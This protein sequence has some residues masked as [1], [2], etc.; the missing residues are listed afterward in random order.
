MSQ[1]QETNQLRKDPLTGKWVIIG[2]RMGKIHNHNYIYDPCQFC[3]EKISR[4]K[5]IARYPYGGINIPWKVLVI[6]NKYALFGTDGNLKRE[7][8]GM[9]D[10][11]N[12][13]GAN[14]VVVETPCHKDK[15]ADLSLEDIE[16]VLKMW[17]WRIEDLKRD[18]CFRYIFIYK[19][20][21]AEAHIRHSHS[22][23][24]STPFIPHRVKEKL[25]KNIL[26]EKK[27]AYCVI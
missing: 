15:F 2:K 4:E 22:Q 9:F 16:I 6:P 1:I 18:K 7:A 12:A 23:I 17:Q 20:E 10:K 13:V 5:E 19:N 27:G 3:P 11:M 21:S 14:E 8:E 25:E 24:I 26:K